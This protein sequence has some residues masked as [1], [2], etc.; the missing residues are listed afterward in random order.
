MPVN[1]NQD[2]HGEECSK[3]IEGRHDK[4]L[5]DAAYIRSTHSAGKLYLAV[6]KRKSSRM[7][8]E[9][10]PNRLQSSGLI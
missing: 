3:A 8:S 6:E 9:L 1:A 2:F 4:E 7:P 10:A 5:V